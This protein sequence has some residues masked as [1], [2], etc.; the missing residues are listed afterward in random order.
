MTNTG[1]KYLITR[2]KRLAFR[3]ENFADDLDIKFSRKNLD[4]ERIQI[5]SAARLLKAA[6]H[7]L[8]LKRSNPN[9]D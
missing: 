3:L 6:I 5:L 7:T 4:V 1:P 2:L 8:N 9:G